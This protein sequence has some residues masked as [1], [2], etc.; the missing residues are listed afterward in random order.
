MV[1]EAD[2]FLTSVVSVNLDEGPGLVA[3]Q[4]LMFLFV[5]IEGSA[6]MVQ[7]LEDAWSGVGAGYNRLIRAGLVAHGQ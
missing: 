4:T 3:T 7:R 6:A 1:E 2:G 5:G